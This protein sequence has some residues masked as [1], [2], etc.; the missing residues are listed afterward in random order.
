MG[1][2]LPTLQAE[3]H[4]GVPL[5]RDPF[6]RA[7]GSGRGGGRLVLVLENNSFDIGRLNEV[8]ERQLEGCHRVDV[9]GR[10]NGHLGVH[11]PHL[12]DTEVLL[13]IDD[14]GSEGDRGDPQMVVTPVGLKRV[15]DHA[16]AG[17]GDPEGVLQYLTVR[18]NDVEGDQ[19]VSTVVW[20]RSSPTPFAGPRIPRGPKRLS[21]RA[22]RCGR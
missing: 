22:G 21:R 6:G 17:R 20:R 19:Q 9:L 8:E 15:P 7:S 1:R 11:R 10:A 3:N 16:F 13:W 2:E 18:G 14:I 4:W 5:L 12:G